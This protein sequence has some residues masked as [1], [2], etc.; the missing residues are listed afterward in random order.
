MS[1]AQQ[2]NTL[3]GGGSLWHFTRAPFACYIP[4]NLQSQRLT[5]EKPLRWPDKVDAQ[6]AIANM[7]ASDFVGL[8]EQYQVSICVMHSKVNQLLPE[9]CNCE[10]QKMWN[11]FPGKKPAFRTEHFKPIDEYPKAVLAQVD[12]ITEQDR[13][14]YAA[15]WQR[16]VR[17]ASIAEARHNKKIMCNKTM[18]HLS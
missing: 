6:E 11:S 2:F 15:A 16:L 14:L 8:A 4:V 12:K 13:Q 18:P 1:L 17:E 3:N 7:H 10:N 5:C 9:Y